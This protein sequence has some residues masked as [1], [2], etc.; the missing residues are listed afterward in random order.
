MFRRLAMPKPLKGGRLRTPTQAVLAWIGGP[1][2]A[3]VEAIAARMG[4][5]IRRNLVARRVLSFPHFLFL[6]WMVILLWGERW[7]FDSKVQ[8]CDWG[9]WEKWVRF[10][11]FLNLH[12][13][14]LDCWFLGAV[15]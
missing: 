12:F 3:T 4:H 11:W 1:A 14:V 6:F 8:R 9:N 2:R 7:V 10:G 13:C 5:Q 15:F